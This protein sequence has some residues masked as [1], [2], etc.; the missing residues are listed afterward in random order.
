MGGTINF[1]RARGW[2]LGIF[3]FCLLAQLAVIAGLDSDTRVW[4]RDKVDLAESLLFVY[5]APFGVICGALLGRRSDESKTADS[6]VPPLVVGL[7]VGCVGLWNLLL[8]A[9]TEWFYLDSEIKVSELKDYWHG[10][11]SAAAFLATAALSYFFA[12]GAARRQAGNEGGQGG[13]GNPPQ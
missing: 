13:S 1:N 10:M 5:S 6:E 11:V 12:T 7:A 3:G 2:L 8:T 4:P 9:T